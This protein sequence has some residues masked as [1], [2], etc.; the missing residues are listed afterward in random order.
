LAWGDQWRSYKEPWIKGSRIVNGTSASA[1]DPMSLHAGV[2][3]ILKVI[4]SAPP[5]PVSEDIQ[6]VLSTRLVLTGLDTDWGTKNMKA[7]ADA[8]KRTLELESGDRVLVLGVSKLQAG[9]RV[10]VTKV[11]DRRKLLEHFE[12]EHFISS[13]PESLHGKRRLAVPSWVQDRKQTRAAR[14]NLLGAFMAKKQKNKCLTDKVP[15]RYTNGLNLVENEQSEIHNRQLIGMQKPTETGRWQRGELEHRKTWTQGK[16]RHNTRGAMPE[17]APK[18]WEELNLPSKKAI[19]IASMDEDASLLKEDTSRA[20]SDN[21]ELQRT[22]FNLELRLQ[23]GAQVQLMQTRMS[24]M[25]LGSPTILTAFVTKLDEELEANGEQTLN[26]DVDRCGFSEP[27]VVLSPN[28]NFVGTV[29]PQTFPPGLALYDGVLPPGA[30]Q[31]PIGTPII[32][33][34]STLEREIIYR[35]SKLDSGDLFSTPVLIGGGVLLGLMFIA[36]MA[37]FYMH[38]MRASSPV[39]PATLQKQSSVTIDLGQDR[40]LTIQNDELKARDIVNYLKGL[41]FK[42][43]DTTMSTMSTDGPSMTKASLEGIARDPDMKYQTGVDGENADQLSDVAEETLSTAESNPKPKRSRFRDWLNGSRP[44]RPVRDPG[45]AGSVSE[46]TQSEYTN[47]TNSQEMMEY[48]VS[49]GRSAAR[50]DD[51]AESQSEYSASQGSSRGRSRSPGEKVVDR[52]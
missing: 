26:L 47:M 42:R 21:S 33:K 25:A 31:V 34:N 6:G 17:E 5:N 38:A 27:V 11:T 2:P 10:G 14:R 22:Q 23:E 28:E 29:A 41:R 40:T 9:N 20:L 37:T 8:L 15:W 12:E 35:G 32:V 36:V 24:L 44:A 43:M 48:S 19:A 52:R 39:E 51:V 16:S 4:W 1:F 30:Y 49:R 46:N 18:T 45:H 13:Q 3:D 7:V 50:D